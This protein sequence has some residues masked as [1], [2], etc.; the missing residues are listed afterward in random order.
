M[1]QIASVLNHQQCN[2]SEEPDEGKPY[3]RDCAGA[4]GVPTA[5]AIKV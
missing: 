3:V 5:R 1:V 4:T 2:L